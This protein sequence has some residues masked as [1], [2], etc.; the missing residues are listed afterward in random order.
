MVAK[1]VLAICMAATGHLTEADFFAAYQPNEAGEGSGADLID[2]VMGY[3]LDETYFGPNPLAGF[4]FRVEAFHANKI[5]SK[6]GLPYVN[7][8]WYPA[9]EADEAA[10]E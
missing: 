9:P 7:Q 6:T 8:R 5:D 4:S 10:A 1:M 2:R 3:T